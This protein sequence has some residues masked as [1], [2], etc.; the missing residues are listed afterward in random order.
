MRTSRITYPRLQNLKSLHSILSLMTL[1]VGS[2]I[3]CDFNSFFARVLLRWRVQFAASVWKVRCYGLK[4]KYRCSLSTANVKI[5]F[6]SLLCFL[7]FYISFSLSLFT[8]K[9]FPPS[10]NCPSQTLRI[11]VDSGR[12]WGWGITLGIT[13]CLDLSIVRYSRAVVFNLGYAKTS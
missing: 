6:S 5:Y 2:Q 10:D 3:I 13:V 9:V 8:H 12:F 1:N 7:S 11:Q 4:Y